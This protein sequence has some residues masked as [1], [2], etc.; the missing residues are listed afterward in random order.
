LAARAFALA[1]GAAA[2]LGFAPFGVPALPVAALAL[3]LLLWHAAATPRAAAA[4]GFAFG[5]GLYGAGVSWVYVALAGFGEMPAPLAAL[6]T[7]AFV[8][9]V[10]LWPALVGWIAAR[11]AP[12]RSIARLLAAAALW[13]LA[14]WTRGWLFTGFPWL[15]LGYAQL[16]GSALAGFAPL[17]GVYLVSLASALAAACAAYALDALAM[18]RPVLRAL[19]VPGAAVVLLLA[20]GA[21]LRA[22]SWTQE[23]GEPLTVSLLQGNV[24]QEQK[25]DPG[26]RAATFRLYDELVEQ[27]RG[28][29][30]VMPE[31]AYPMFGNQLP[32]SVVRG[33]ADVAA[34]RDGLVLAGLFTAEPP[35]PG[36]TDRRFY[37]T[38]AALGGE[39]VA[40]YRKRHLVPFGESIPFKAWLG[41]LLDRVL[42]IP[43]A[44][45]TAGDADQAP[46]AVAGHR[47][48]VN[49][50]YEDAFG[51]ELIGA[52]R[53]ADILVN[54]T[55]DAWYGHSIAAWQH[56]QIAAMR[57]LELGRPM[58][59]STNTGVTSYIDADGHVRALLPWFTRG[60]LDVTLRGREGLTPFVR[61]GNAVPVLAC[62]ALAA[63]A[64]FAGRRRR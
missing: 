11:L 24:A 49:I 17:G 21:A 51:S 44:D 55:N 20:A 3:L 15:A 43:L 61:F 9:Y 12:A 47:V 16:P 62:L 4:L 22:V 34:Q 36:T 58:L 37:N 59:R 6:A 32:A 53:S 27:S 26:F 14:E 41:P 54:V 23:H 57:A 60:V 18:R 39:E 50:C 38:V 40:L 33:L 56:N 42:A 45:Q 28:R 46:F 30:V 52:A 19:G 8:A 2:V 48:A 29:L 5:L 7:I 25:F 13:P 63:G 31:S 35:L 10:A 1:A 64:V